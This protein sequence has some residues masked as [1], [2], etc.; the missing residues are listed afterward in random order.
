MDVENMLVNKLFSTTFNSYIS[1][2]KLVKLAYFSLWTELFP[3]TYAHLATKNIHIQTQILKAGA[4]VVA[5]LK[6]I[7]E[8]H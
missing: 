3:F 7:F 1:Q 4:M 8:Q 5:V 2:V 6:I